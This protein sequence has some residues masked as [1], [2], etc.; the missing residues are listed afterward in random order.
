LEESK[1]EPKKEVKQEIPIVETPIDPMEDD[2]TPH[3]QVSP[4]N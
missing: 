3:R 4:T 2:I 1:E